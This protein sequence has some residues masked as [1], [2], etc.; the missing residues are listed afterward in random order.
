MAHGHEYRGGFLKP[1]HR[2]SEQ[3]ATLQI[4]ELDDTLELVCEVTLTARGYDVPS[5]SM[6]ILR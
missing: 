6:G 4:H 3:R 5:G 1:D 2:A